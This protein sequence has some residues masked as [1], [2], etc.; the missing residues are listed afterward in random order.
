MTAAC[1]LKEARLVAE[2][3]D[4]GL[5]RRARL[6][7]S[8]TP[9]APVRSADLFAGRQSQLVRMLD[10]VEAPGEH[11]VVFGERGVGK[12]SLAVVA[13]LMASM[14]GHLEIRVNCQLDDDTSMIWQRTGEAIQRR[15]RLAEVQEHLSSWPESLVTGALPLL[16]A[17]HA[18]SNDALTALELLQAG[19]R[20]LLTLD[21]FDRLSD[22]RTK[23]E[24]VDMM[25]TIS[26]QSLDVTIA[27]VGV[28]DD[29]DSLIEHHE[30]IARALNEIE[31]PR[32]SSDEL[33]EIITKG[34]AQADMTADEP[35]INF[36]TNISM[37]LPHYTH[38]LGLHAGLAAVGESTRQVTLNH[39][40]RALPRVAE[41]AEQHVKRLWHEATHSTRANN[42]RE[43]LLAAA[44]T[45]TDGRGYFAPGDMRA[46][47]SAIMGVP[48]GISRFA[49]TLKK[50][51]EERGPV[52][53][54]TG[55]KNRPRY[56]FIEPLLIPYTCIVAISANLVDIVLVAEFLASRS[57]RT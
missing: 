52:L 28:A 8:F 27:V 18:S 1:C 40:V 42:F 21:E 6:Q 47:M 51:A 45:P 43:T 9:A 19:G 11:V 30:S 14:R 31:M 3:Q 15:E 25:K 26:D 13:G 39:V 24:I 22:S 20:V 2:L 5:K 12:T 55:V 37:G 23:T 46:A 38:L 50:F 44:L 16:T 4:E 56:R 57:A 34:L 32:M 33:A 54:R 41:R 36:I 29:V 48:V 7:R 53:Q 49:G 17:P 10:S 35:A